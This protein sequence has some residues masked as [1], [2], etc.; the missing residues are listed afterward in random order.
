M[1][2]KILKS[3]F[4]EQAIKDCI[5]ALNKNKECNAAT[6]N[7]GYLLGSVG[8]L[9]QVQIVVTRNED[10]FLDDFEVVVFNK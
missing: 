5:V 3:L 2:D 1:K 7:A 6:S 8:E 9:L 10:Q 4:T